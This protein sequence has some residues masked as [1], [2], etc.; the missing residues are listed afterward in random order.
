MPWPTD[1]DVQTAVV[2]V[3]TKAAVADVQIPSGLAEIITEANAAAQ[4]DLTRILVLKGYTP[5]QI[6]NW[7]DAFQYGLDQAKFWGLVNCGG[8]GEYPDKFV[9]ALDRREELTRAPAILIGG[10]PVAPPV[11]GSD[12]GGISSG[13]LDAVEHF[14]DDRDLFS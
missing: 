2:A 14:R 13:R 12:V 1:S 4:A 10:V 11:G 9:K 7:D 3:L 6:A 5:L 8:L